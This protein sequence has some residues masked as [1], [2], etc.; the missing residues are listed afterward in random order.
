MIIGH[1]L[2]AK[3]IYDIQMKAIYLKKKSFILIFFKKTMSGGPFI[4]YFDHLY[5]CMF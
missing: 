3:L 1:I 4:G 5:E 2:K